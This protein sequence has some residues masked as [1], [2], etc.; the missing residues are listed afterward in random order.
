MKECGVVVAGGEMGSPL[1]TISCTGR[2]FGA[3]TAS[4]EH[5]IEEIME[6]LKGDKWQGI[7]QT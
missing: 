7:K 5:L 4:E 2:F 3:S 6:Q 1:H